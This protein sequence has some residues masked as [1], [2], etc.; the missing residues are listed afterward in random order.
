MHRTVPLQ[1]SS[2]ARKKESEK[3]KV[4]KARC[5]REHSKMPGVEPSTAKANSGGLRSKT[6]AYN[7]RHYP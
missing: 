2:H 3:S 4:G 7:T 5:N 6:S 1:G